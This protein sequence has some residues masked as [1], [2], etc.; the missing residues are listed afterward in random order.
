MILQPL[1]HRNAFCIFLVVPVITQGPV[2]VASKVGESVT[3]T[4]NATG[5]PLPDITWSRDS[6][7]VIMEQPGDIMI[8]NITDGMTRQSQLMLINLKDSDFQ[9]YTCNAS[10]RFGSDSATALLGS[11]LLPFVFVFV[12]VCVCVYVCMCVCVCV[13]MCTCM[14]VHVCVY[15]YVCTCVCVYMYVCTCVCLCTCVCECVYMCAY[16]CTC[17]RESVCVT[18]YCYIK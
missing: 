8:T 10:N 15:M 3:F 4:C 13:C 2:D 1:S 11:E 9:N 7:G 18:I 12:C 5:E 6:G 14:C 17:I 16:V